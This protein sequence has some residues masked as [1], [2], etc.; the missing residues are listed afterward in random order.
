MTI[1]ISNDIMKSG[2][3]FSDD[4][5]LFKCFTEKRCICCWKWKMLSD[6]SNQF[7]TLVLKLIVFY[8][9]PFQWAIKYMQVHCVMCLM[10]Y[11]YFCHVLVVFPAWVGDISTWLFQLQVCR[12]TGDP[13]KL[14]YCK[15][16]DG[17]YHCYC[18]QPPHKVCVIWLISGWSSFLSLQC[19][20]N[21]WTCRMWAVDLTCVRSIQDVI[22]VGQLSLEVVLAQGTLNFCCNFLHDPPY[23]S[24][25]V[26]W[27]AM[28]MVHTDV[29]TYGTMGYIDRL[30][31]TAYTD[32]L[33]DRYV[34]PI[35][36]GTT[37]YGEPWFSVHN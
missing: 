36:S 30:V 4:Y 17:A 27:P 6:A 28:G 12:R 29:L 20:L 10:S 33:L 13:N 37:W 2:Y 18:Q 32:P 24:E 21:N 34:P 8:F 16:C 35:L 31:F 7:T 5:F 25:L 15:R 19:Q 1:F 3:W 22:A 23:Q 9:N 26:Y 14:M 11:A